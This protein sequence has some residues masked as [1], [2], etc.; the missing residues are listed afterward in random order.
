MDRLLE[1]RVVV[2]TGAGSGIGRAE[3]IAAAAHGARVVVN[4][5]GTSADG[6]GSSRGPADAVVKE[7]ENAGNIA[8]ASYDSVAEKT[9]AE[10]IIQKAV[11]TY[12]RIDALVNNAGVVREPRNVSEIPDDDWEIIMKT[13]LF[14]TFFATRA[15]CS[16]MREQRYGRIVNTSSHVGLGWQGFAAYGAAKEGIAGFTRT[17]ARDMAEFC[18]TCNALRPIA[19]WRG[20]KEDLP[21]V[22]INRPE[23]VAALVVYLVSEQADHINGCIFEVWKGHVSIFQEPPPVQQVLKKSGSWT[24]EELADAVPQNLTRGRSRQELPQILN[25]E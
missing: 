2:I 1:G 22:A 16:F 24:T 3:A 11:D 17:V 4:D 25:L 6:I 12:G 15:A 23:D 13:H 10:A 19:A 7:I 9:G 14:G 5:I 20:T 18:V 8:V 21:R